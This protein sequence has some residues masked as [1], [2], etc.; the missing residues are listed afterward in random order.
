MSIQRLRVLGAAAAVMA[1][2]SVATPAVAHVSVNPAEAEKGSLA[3]LTF[4]VPNER[5]NAATTKVEVTLDP[6]HPI[7]KVDVHPTTGWSHSI[8]RNRS[9]QTAGGTTTTATAGTITWSGGRIGPGESQEFEV[10]MGPIPFDA[11][12]LV[13]KTVQTYDNGEVVRWIDVPTGDDEPEHPA[14][15]LTLTEGAGEGGDGATET[16]DGEDTPDTG[17]A[18]PADDEDGN[19]GSDDG[20][21]LVAVI[22]GGAALVL[23]VIALLRSGRRRDPEQ[24]AS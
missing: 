15:I 17:A 24:Q 3:K 20:L 12:R 23:S 8:E 1:I 11:D 9:S 6:D 16:H 7:E 5:D 22:I 4:R 13:F 2:A 10:S 21:G 19:D 18:V 14:P